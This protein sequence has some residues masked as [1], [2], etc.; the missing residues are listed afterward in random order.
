M[1]PMENKRWNGF[2]V[3]NGSQIEAK[4]TYIRLNTQMP[5]PPRGAACGAE[6]FVRRLIPVNTK[7]RFREFVSPQRARIA[8]GHGCDRPS[9]VNF[10]PGRHRFSGQ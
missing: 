9:Y 7:A 3:T 4:L 2:S 10:K 1:M 6:A 5:C 8:F